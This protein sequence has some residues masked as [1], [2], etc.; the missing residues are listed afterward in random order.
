M[1]F[2]CPRKKRTRAAEY[3]AKNVSNTIHRITTARPTQRRKMSISRRP[4]TV[5]TRTRNEYI[6]ATANECLRVFNKTRGRRVGTFFEMLVVAKFGADVR[7]MVRLGIRD[8]P[9][10]L[11]RLPRAPRAPKKCSFNS[12]FAPFDDKFRSSG[13]F[14]REFNARYTARFVFSDY[15]FLKYRRRFLS[16]YSLNVYRNSY[17]INSFREYRR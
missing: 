6:R 7:L 9:Y 16:V 1:V 2:R 5:P 3:I 8:I 4:S 17:R 12:C 11:A 10:D 15:I 13:R 14:R